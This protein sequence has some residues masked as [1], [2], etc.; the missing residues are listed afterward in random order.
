MNTPVVK[1]NPPRSRPES[2][3]VPLACSLGLL[4][5][6]VLLNSIS[7]PAANDVE[8]YYNYARRTLQG[9]LPYRDFFIEYPPLALLFFMPPALLSSLL[10]GISLPAYTLWLHC[11]FFGLNLACLWLIYFLL[12]SQTFSKTDKKARLQ[13]FTWGSVLISLYLLQRF[14]IGIAFLT[15]LAIYFFQQQKPGWAGV[16]LALGTLAKLYPALL[17]PLFFGLYWYPGRD[18]RSIIR[19]GVGFGVGGLVLLLPF[20]LTGLEGLKSF[21]VFQGERGLE[22]ESLFAGLVV[23]GSY[24]HL[25]QALSMVEHGGLGLA[26]YWVRSLASAST[27]LTLVGEAVLLFFMWRNLRKEFRLPQ[28]D[29]LINA[30]SLLILWFILANKVIS[31]QYLIW[32]LVLAPFWRSKTTQRLLLLTLPLSIIA[33]PFLVDWLILLD[34]LPFAILAVRNTLLVA[35][36]VRLARDLFIGPFDRPEKAIISDQSDHEAVS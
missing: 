17:L 5:V 30:A 9:E 22:L 3:L 23:L 16:M 1:S 25:T 35:I 18:R 11:E 2:W 36:F 32:L 6:L 7:L 27:L 15:L 12:R 21:L 28:F 14:D 10:G 26:S 29:W 20:L 31:P 24:L 34:P 8:I 33:F 13:S 4:V 19:C